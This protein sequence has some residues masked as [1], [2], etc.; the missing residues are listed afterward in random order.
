VLRP[1]ALGRGL[2]LL[3]L[4]LLW[5]WLATLLMLLW[6]HLRCRQTTRVRELLL[7]NRESSLR[8]RHHPLRRQSHAW[9]GNNS[10]SAEHNFQGILCMAV[11]RQMEN[12]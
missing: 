12:H 1:G 11:V 7:L 10:V 4:L 2:L 8:R 9:D 6:L 3:L 5:W